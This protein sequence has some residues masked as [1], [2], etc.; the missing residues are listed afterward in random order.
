MLGAFSAAAADV[1]DKEKMLATM[2]SIIPKF[3]DENKNAFEMG[4]RM[5]KS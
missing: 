5:V 4:Y 3:K 2:L 1:L